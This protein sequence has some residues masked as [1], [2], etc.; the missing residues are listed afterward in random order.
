MQEIRFVCPKCGQKLE[1]ELKMAG[2]KIQCPACKNS[3]NVPNP[4]PPTAKLPRVRSNSAEQI[5]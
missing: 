2:Q 4:Y 5:E 3:I 1:C